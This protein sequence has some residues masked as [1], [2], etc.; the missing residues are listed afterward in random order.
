MGFD[1]GYLLEDIGTS[2]WEMLLTL[3]Q[4]SCD[5]MWMINIAS[6]KLGCVYLE[7][8]IEFVGN[9]YGIRGCLQEAW[10]F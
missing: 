3:F 1:L 10:P 5:F 4:M 7:E 2:F 6:I 9:R 8:L